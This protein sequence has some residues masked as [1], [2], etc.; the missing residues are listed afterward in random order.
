[1]MQKKQHFNYQKLKNLI[2]FTELSSNKVIDII[3]NHS[4]Y[5]INAV[6]N[7]G[8]PRPGAHDAAP[9]HLRRCQLNL[10][11]CGREHLA[12]KP[13]CL[14]H[15]LDDADRGVYDLIESKNF[16]SNPSINEQIKLIE[17]CHPKSQY[18]NYK[19]QGWSFSKIR[20]DWEKD[21]IP[22]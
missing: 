3:H 20:V 9:D 19:I 8:P 16:L 5:P 4:P 17:S 7:V 18:Y 10:S 22:F 13:G 11:D 15:C 6:Q 2:R 12:R 21:S 1:M 14:C